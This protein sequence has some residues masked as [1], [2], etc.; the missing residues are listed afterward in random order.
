MAYSMFKNEVQKSIP[1][2]EKTVKEW[3]FKRRP[4]QGIS[5]GLSTPTTFVNWD[6]LERDRVKIGRNAEEI[7]EIEEPRFCPY[8]CKLLREDEK[9]PETM[10]EAAKAV[11]WTLPSSW[12]EE[13]SDVIK[14]PEYPE[15]SFIGNLEVEG[16][17][18]LFF[19]KFYKL[20]GIVQDRTLFVYSEKQVR[21]F[22][23]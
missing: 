4:A 9:I 15:A 1:S 8:S 10:E 2:E 17:F 21:L 18:F 13:S 6:K 22:D 3:N 5:T 16:S 14:T 12:T 7:D 11:D 23:R 20:F 19:Q